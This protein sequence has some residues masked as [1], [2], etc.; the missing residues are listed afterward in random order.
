MRKMLIIGNWKM[1]FTVHEASLHLHRL[2]ERIKEHRD[3]E[4]V[5]APS[6]LTLQPLSL[7]LDR[8]KFRLAAQ[9][10]FYKDEGAYTGE[11]SFTML[12]DM[13]HYA[14]IGHSERRIYFHESLD[15]VRDKVSAAVRNKI[16]PVLFIGET[17][18]EHK[19]GETKQVLHD[20]LTTA[21]SDLTAGDVED[22][23]I[24]YEPVWA[25]STFG[26][27]LAKP[28]EVES[29]MK[30]IRAEVSELYGE[31]A[32]Q[33]VRILYGG[34]VDEQIV[35]GYIELPDCDGA[36]PGAASLNYHKF[37]AI[38]EAASRVVQ[39]RRKADADA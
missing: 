6:L 37:A 38:I 24:V 28:D 12:R 2:S 30:R 33:S 32:A 18:E 1:H 26:G 15:I 14:L 16:T 13:V 7:E 11:V 29:A 34:S 5:L 20:Q 3:L 22:M 25:I 36:V 10:G 19:D 39:E 27:I 17:Y 23:V 4:V 8:H 31:R 21:L 35:R 9:N